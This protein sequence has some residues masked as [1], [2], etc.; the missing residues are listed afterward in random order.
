MTEEFKTGACHAG[1]YEG[2]V[3]LAE[4][5]RLVRTEIA[6]ALDPNPN[7]LSEAIGQGAASFADAG[8]DRAYFGWPAEATAAEGQDTVKVLGALLA[9]AVLNDEGGR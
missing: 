3:V 6:E 9:E 7:S 8:G 1:R 4:E 5:P 2:S